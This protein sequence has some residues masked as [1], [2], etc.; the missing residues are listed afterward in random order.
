MCHCC[1]KTK[2]EKWVIIPVWVAPLSISRIDYKLPVYVKQCTGVA[3]TLSYLQGVNPATRMG[4]VSLLFNN[5][6]NH[7]INFEVEWKDKH[8]RMDKILLK[9]E[10]PIVSA[11]RVSGFYRNLTSVEHTVNIYLQYIALSDED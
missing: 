2:F 7:P 5:K 8:F 10:V 9:M 6:R 4:E 11:T 3:F 1:C